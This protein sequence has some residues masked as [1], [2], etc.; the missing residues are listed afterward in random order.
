MEKRMGLDVGKKLSQKP[1]DS[2]INI[3]PKKK[4][5]GFT[6]FTDHIAQQLEFLNAKQKHFARSGIYKDTAAARWIVYTEKEKDAIVAALLAW[7]DHYYA[8]DT[9]GV[10]VTTVEHLYE[11]WGDEWPTFKIS[12]ELKNVLDS[13][14]AKAEKAIGKKTLK[15]AKPAAAQ[16]FTDDRDGKTYRTVKIGEQVWMGENLNFE[17]PNSWCYD[18]N[19]DNCKKY[20]RL[21]SWNAAMKACPDDWHLPFRKEWCELFI[22]AGGEDIAGMKLKS[23][24]PDWD[25][26]DDYSFLA[27]P[28]GGRITNGSFGDLGS[29]GGWWTATENDSSNAYNWNMGADYT[30]AYEFDNNKIDGFSVRCLRD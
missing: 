4:L 5:R 28:G 26:T 15:S 23:K 13:I 3:T 24:S 16:T 22:F 25:G 27:L 14:N 18:N 6:Q 17:T 19:P 2:L 1:S 10:T 8:N 7:G 20:G 11:T 30:D 29:W 21:Y 12:E 9:E